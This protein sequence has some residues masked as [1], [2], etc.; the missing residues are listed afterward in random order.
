VDKGR[1]HTE[2]NPAQLDM[3]TR[4]ALNC[5]V[6][7]IIY[8]DPKGWAMGAF[9]AMPAIL[10]LSRGRDWLLVGQIYSTSKLMSPN[11]QPAAIL[12]FEV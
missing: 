1:K 11:D 6:R 3:Y 12:A 4:I 7:I 9:L 10:V 2:V 5:N 8:P